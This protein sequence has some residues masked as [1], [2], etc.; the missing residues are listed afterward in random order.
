MEAGR[1]SANFPDQGKELLFHQQQPRL[2]MVE[3]VTKIPGCEAHVERQ[4]DGAGLHHP[5]VGFQ[6]PVRIAAEIGHHRSG[7]DAQRLQQAG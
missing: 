6:Q 3:D 5:V 4:K 2:G 7:L 1:H